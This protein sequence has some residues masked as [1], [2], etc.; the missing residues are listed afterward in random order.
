MMSI[1]RTFVG[2]HYQITTTLQMR[3]VSNQTN[4]KAMNI[5]F[6]YIQEKSPVGFINPSPFVSRLK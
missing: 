4:S 1:S 5:R 6:M 2:I 3:L